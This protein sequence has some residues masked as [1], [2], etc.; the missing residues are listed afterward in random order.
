VHC[1]SARQRTGVTLPGDLVRFQTVNSLD[2][3]C[4]IIKTADRKDGHLPW[5]VGEGNIIVYEN[6]GRNAQLI[7]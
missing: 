6:G 1:R 7:K 2:G 3:E 4:A 5:R